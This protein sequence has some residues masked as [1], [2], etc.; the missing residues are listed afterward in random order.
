MTLQDLRSEIDKIDYQIHDLLNKRA[1]IALK[2]GKL[3]VEADGDKTNFYRPDRE[4]EILKAIGE[5][6]QGPLEDEAV[7]E[8]FRVI[9]NQ[10]RKL[11]EAT[12]KSA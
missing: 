2:V 4:K 1:K 7:M 5:Y 6:N 8:V 9:I 12:Y 11:Q 10:C 3:K